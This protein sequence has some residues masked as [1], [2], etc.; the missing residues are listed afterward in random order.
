MSACAYSIY[1]YSIHRTNQLQ[2]HHHP[3]GPVYNN[4]TMLKYSYAINLQESLRLRSAAPNVSQ[5]SN[6]DARANVTVIVAK[7]EISSGGDLLFYIALDL[8]LAD[9][10][11]N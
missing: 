4:N 9:S 1:F 10:T 8:E 11:E 3:E 6:A 5:T 7:N 2:Y